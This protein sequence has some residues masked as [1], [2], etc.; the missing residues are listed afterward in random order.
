MLGLAIAAGSS[1]LPFI[2]RIGLSEAAAWIGKGLAFG[3]ASTIAGL[4]IKS[5][6]GDQIGAN[7]PL[8]VKGQRKEQMQIGTQPTLRRMRKTKKSK[9]R[10]KRR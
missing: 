6:A 7:E 1:L 8:T 9:R 2:S 5:S 3:S 4:A 10:S